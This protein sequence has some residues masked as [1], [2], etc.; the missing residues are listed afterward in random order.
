MP[1]DFNPFDDDSLL[2]DWMKDDPD[3]SAPGET[4][5]TDQGL[6]PASEWAREPGR[7][8]PSSSAEEDLRRDAL[9]DLPWLDDDLSGE[10]EPGDTPLDDLLEEWSSDAA[11]FDERLSGTPTPTPA[12]P[13]ATEGDLDWLSEMA[14]EPEADD[15]PGIPA[16]SGLPDWLAEM[17]PPPE[18]AA[19]EFAPETPTTPE[20]E[21]PVHDLLGAWLQE[22]TFNAVPEFQPGD[23]TPPSGDL[24]A[25]SGEG[26][27][28]WP[29][30]ADFGLLDALHGAGTE[31]AAEEADVPAPGVLPDWLREAQQL[32]VTDGESLPDWMQGSGEPLAEPEIP[33]W[34]QPPAEP[35]VSDAPVEEPSAGE[36]LPEWVL[37][38]DEEPEAPAAP[39]LTFDAWEE[40][41]SEAA[42]EAQKT[43]E[44]RMLEEVPDWFSGLE[45]QPPQSEAPAA[46][47]EQ[48]EQE[49][50]PGWFMG[51]EEQ[52]VEEAPDWFQ[53]IDYSG[54]DL[55]QPAPDVPA[56][57]TDL[58]SSGSELPDW[59]MG[60]NPPDA[61]QIDWSAFE[62]PAEQE[63]AGTS[64]LKRL[65]EQAEHEPAP[66]AP[67]TPEPELPLPFD[68]KPPAS[69]P[70][71]PLPFGIEPPAPEAEA[72]APT[73]EEPQPDLS[74]LFHVE[75]EAEF[76]PAGE[77]PEMDLEALF[78]AAPEEAAEPELAAE[79]DFDALFGDQLAASELSVAEPP[80][81]ESLAAQFG[82][83]IEPELIDEEEPVFP[84][85]D[86]IA[87]PE[88]IPFP[89][90]ELDQ[91]MPTGDTEEEL[92]AWMADFVP[93][94]ESE[95][96]PASDFVERFDPQAATPLDE[97]APDWLRT[98]NEGEEPSRVT[99]EQPMASAPRGGDEG[100][101][102]WLSG[103]SSE[104]VVPEPGTEPETPQATE[105]RASEAPQ[106]GDEVDI[107]S[108][109]SLY[110]PPPEP[111]P[112]PEPEPVEEDELPP[113]LRLEEPA[114]VWEIFGTP[115]PHEAEEGVEPDFEALLDDAAL[116]TVDDLFPLPP[117]HDAQAAPGVD[118]L[119]PP[120]P[121]SAFEAAPPTETPLAEVG[122]SADAAFQPDWVAELRPSEVPVTVRAGGVSVD[123]EQLP[124][125]DLP[126][127]LQVFRETTLRD[128]SQPPKPAP[129]SESG[130]LA[131]IAGALSPFDLAIP[132]TVPP[133]MGLAV[134]RDQQTR[135]DRL[136]RMLDAAAGDDVIDEDLREPE[137]FTS[138]EE[139]AA[140]LEEVAPRAHRRRVRRFKLDR[141]LIV[142]VLLAGLIAPF[143]TDALHF[144][145]DPPALSGDRQAVA[146]AVA[147]LDAGDTVLVALEY[148][149]TAA[150]ELDPLLE[151]VLRD[152]L[153]HR[154]IPL[155]TGTD[156]A[157]A[158]HARA[159]IAPLATDER[160]LD[161]RDKNETALEA[162]QD[163]YLLGYI[164]GDA[165][166]VRALRGADEDH[167]LALPS[168]FVTDIDGEATGLN[169]DVADDVALIV[170]V[171]ESSDD[172]RRWAEQMG[173]ARV[174]M[175]ALV[176]AAIEPL[177][178]SYVNDDGYLGYLAGYRDT[179]SYDAAQNA[180]TRTPYSPPDD[181]G[182]D[183]PD[184]D[185]ARW[186]STA[187]GA[188]LAAG[189]IA[190][191]LIINLFRA[192]VRRG[193]S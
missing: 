185:A 53:E 183:L 100:G 51:L 22:D 107:D 165:T 91:E 12:V 64:P 135:A 16:P 49:F 13:A 56:A 98:L 117:G 133:V 177:A 84:G 73:A 31:D 15:K 110:T 150:G 3:E 132:R 66:A 140:A 47:D 96:E 75:P 155:T 161:V 1:D 35:P 115:D 6:P 80:K 59:F 93:P 167:P 81:E 119:F 124:V 77:I 142:L 94:A 20:P 175:V 26:E 144:A 44:E 38:A 58:P 55:A 9:S 179:R 102:D 14:A 111:A 160:L 187:L 95:E 78:G 70:E 114:D 33:G 27:L 146:D 104:D 125:I 43:P 134:T 171:G 28:S 67:E 18:S 83:E 159:V 126:D 21:T 82:V 162:G 143:A 89:E 71:V 122:T 17:A 180:E 5:D 168:P 186:N 113:E 74:E 157:G 57:P 158:L 191:G 30:E 166:G 181:L 120:D 154:A 147:A 41:Q 149:P 4:S 79:L 108:L 92:E 54:G 173:D 36:H 127:Q 148:G 76:A 87:G 48:A 88:D 106:A 123:V 90:L 121:Q 156:I 170:V 128:L 25:L 192:L 61:D 7:T 169:L 34:V 138:L 129:A 99:S 176:T 130:P 188:A 139:E 45:G 178:S 109:L 145:A 190:L 103:I 97:N 153:A 40:E 65:S 37:S 63:V 10:P 11:F 131:G 137:M 105:T 68:I 174:P 151:A 164:P 193:R 46:P 23:L 163:Y 182:F 101:L 32:N 189:L 86:A 42:R 136:R 69:E 39:G 184:L 72:E 85:A 118:D 2:P 141:V 116:P 50:V 60:L 29:D 62:A 52:S 24:E 112:L 19:P 172:V 8:R 152:V